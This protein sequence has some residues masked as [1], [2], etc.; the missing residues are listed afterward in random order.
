[1]KEVLG[2]ERGQTDPERA[3]SEGQGQSERGR[4]DH[5]ESDLTHDGG[6][7]I[8]AADRGGYQRY[9]KQRRDACCD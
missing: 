6:S 5:R 8:T 4:C 2:D 9:S 1:M 3:R 7:G